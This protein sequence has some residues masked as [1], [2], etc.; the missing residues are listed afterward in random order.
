MLTDDEPQNTHCENT[1]V[2]TYKKDTISNEN[3]QHNNNDAALISTKICVWALVALSVACLISS[4]FIVIYPSYYIDEYYYDYVRVNELSA[5]LTSIPIWVNTV[6]ILIPIIIFIHN[7]QRI[8]KKCGVAFT[9]YLIYIAA[10]FSMTISSAAMACNDYRSATLWIVA[11]LSFIMLILTLVI[12]IT[13]KF[14][15]KTDHKVKVMKTK[16]EIELDKIKQLY[17]NNIVTQTEYEKMRQKIIEKYYN[18]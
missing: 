8:D 1:T 16:L 6:I 17:D 12:V 9:I 13:N 3:F 11:A 7:K 15:F 18:V 14:V 5:F 2:I 4:I 10:T